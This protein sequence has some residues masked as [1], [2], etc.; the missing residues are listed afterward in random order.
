MKTRRI[1]ENGEYFGNDESD[2]FFK[3]G[4]SKEKYQIVT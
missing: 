2:M 3:M 4:L 1:D